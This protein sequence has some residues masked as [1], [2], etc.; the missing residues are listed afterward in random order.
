MVTR[1]IEEQLD[2]FTGEPAEDIETVTFAYA[3]KSYEIDLNDDNRKVFD[4][5]MGEYIEV[6]RRLTGDGA[7]GGRGQRAARSTSNASRPATPDR[8]QNQAIR[9]WARKQGFQVN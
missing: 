5:V 4:E 6:A 8:E 3:G 2:D 7:R 1:I 9:E